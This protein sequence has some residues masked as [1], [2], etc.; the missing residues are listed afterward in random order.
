MFK[1]PIFWIIFLILAVAGVLFLIRYFP[2][3][4][5]FVNV[6]IT[7]NRKEAETEAVLLS[8]EL[9]LGPE[10]YDTAAIFNS[11]YYTQIYVELEGG[12]KTVFNQMLQ[13]DLYKPYKWEVRLFKENE[14]REVNISF[15]PSGERYGFREK[16]PETLAGVNLSKEEAITLAEDFLQNHWA[17]D[18]SSFE[19]IE[20]KNNQ[21]I[22]GRI[23]HT[24]VYERI[25][26]SLNEAKYRLRTTVS[27]DRITEVSNYMKIPEAFGRR[28]SEMR[29]ANN[30]IATGGQIAMAV[31]YGLG[32]ILIGSFLLLRKR[33]L[34]WK[35]GVFWAFVVAFL[36]FISSFNYLSLSW[37]WYDTAISKS[38]F[39][40]QNLMQNFT[41]FLTDFI[42]LAL[43][44][45]AAESLSRKAF[46]KHIQFWKIWSKDAAGSD[47]VIGNTLAGYIVTIFSLSYITVF[48][49][50]TTKYMNWWNPSSMMINP[51]V[52]ATPFPWFSALA[53]ALHAGFW[54]EALFRAVP[55]AG[56][57]LIGQR[58]NKRGLF[59]ILGLILQLLIF[60]AGH[61]NYAAQPSYARVVELIVP[62]LL[63]AFLFLRFG[64]LTAVILH[65]VFDAVLMSMPVWV[66]A[67]SSLLPSK[68]LLVLFLFIPVWVILFKKLKY[69]R[70]GKLDEKY[71][72]QSWQPLPVK[73]EDKTAVDEIVKEEKFRLTKLLIILGI[74]GFV[75]WGMVAEFSDFT[76]PL[77]TGKRQAIT[78]AENELQAQNIQLDDEWR[79]FAEVINS[80]TEIDRYVWQEG[81]TNLYTEWLGNL[82]PS[83]RWRVRYVKF[84]GDV[85]E[86]AEEYVFFIK[87][88]SQVY[89]FTHSL[90]ENRE[91]AQLE[92]DTAKTLAL[93]ALQQLFS[94]NSSGWKEISAAPEK[95]PNR[96][97]WKFV[98]SDT[99]NYHLNDS[100]LRYV[101]EIS[102][103]RVT[104]LVRYI[105][106]PEEWTREQKNLS[107]TADS[108]QG[109]IG[110]IVFMLYF[111]S[112]LIAIISWTKRKFD[113]RFFLK[114]LIILTIIQ[115][116][117]LINKW[118]LLVMGFSS[119]QPYN[120]QVLAVILSRSLGIVI[121]SLSMSVIGGWIKFRTAKRGSQGKSF[122]PALLWAGVIAAVLGAVKILTPVFGPFKADISTLGY[123]LPFLAEML[124]SIRGYVTS[125]ILV[126]VIFL[127]V[128]TISGNWSRKRVVTILASLAL[129]W[130][131]IASQTLERLDQVSLIFIFTGGIFSAL[132]FLLLYKNFLRFHPTDIPLVTG[133][134]YSLDI[135]RSAFYG[136]YPQE[137]V[138][139]LF[140][141]ITLT[142]FV[143]L[144]RK[145]LKK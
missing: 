109:F 123:S 116:I 25:G 103:D 121:F 141:L 19:L 114:M 21:V 128:H 100:E 136:N 22:S 24:F 144:W 50:L 56:M 108:L 70:S 104:T 77:L 75:I 28:Y 38:A 84:T 86:R 61:A 40:F 133:V 47:R 23:D 93:Y 91:G 131:L 142:V 35:K 54:E 48:Y 74:A 9:D 11:D 111:I 10:Q 99:L 62:S 130:I 65:F 118:P 52:L 58:L 97:D 53:T 41:S 129:F 88:R 18:L 83:S 37:F 95:L 92:E 32:G 43:S 117:D 80:S 7:M 106:V 102:G 39:I 132:I 60:G 143:L 137:V 63:F 89:S 12:G 138:Y 14:P 113:H 85:A 59:L 73:I 45:I 8:K 68:V 55:L 17:I 57:M 110:I 90:P 69:N 78:A 66:S 4:M 119:S 135:L 3:V 13:E 105:Y 94:I 72:N 51:N 81:G 139:K 79:V 76:E 26:V 107:R 2:D 36:G 27:G 145:A 140:A 15:T 125:T 49:F 29:S 71:L 82:I 122:L 34:L 46:P 134:I 5:S 31:F 67:D 98:F 1:K 87:D 112:F 124:S 6:D 64:L 101:A 127:L 120:N 44:F 42:L 126:F 30:T 115:I 16:L 20:E 33:W 96:R